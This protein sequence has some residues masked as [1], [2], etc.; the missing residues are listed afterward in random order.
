[1]GRAATGFEAA[2]ATFDSI[3]EDS[4]GPYAETQWRRV[5]STL[6]SDAWVASV[7]RT[8]QGFSKALGRVDRR[9][10]AI[11]A[12][13][14]AVFLWTVALGA[15]EGGKSARKHYN[16]LRMAWSGA[17]R[18][19][20]GPFQCPPRPYVPPFEDIAQAVCG[21]SPLCKVRHLKTASECDAHMQGVLQ[22]TA[23][24]A[25]DLTSIAGGVGPG[26]G[27]ALG[28]AMESIVSAVR[29]QS[30]VRFLSATLANG[31]S[32]EFTI[33]N[34]KAK[35][36]IDAKGFRTPDGTHVP[37]R[38]QVS[39]AAPLPIRKTHARIASRQSHPTLPRPPSLSVSLSHPLSR[40]RAL[41]QSFMHAR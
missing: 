3:L 33:V 28:A 5:A 18:S 26:G 2:Q 25:I 8:K 30:H 23:I 21:E 35:K 20:D 22:R 19:D 11:V 6:P 37:Y 7:G 39:L 41:R 24:D 4:V 12:V 29:S 34:P 17:G 14:A 27:P 13:A 38:V 36:V 16:A 10:A 32:V 1:M 9:V 15:A 31:Y 40:A